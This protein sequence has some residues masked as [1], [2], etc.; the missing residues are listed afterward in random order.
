MVASPAAIAG[1][2]SPSAMVSVDPPLFCRGLRKGSPEMF[3][4]PV[5]VLE[6]SIIDP[7]ST[8]LLRLVPMV[9]PPT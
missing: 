2:P 4:E 8:R 6:E 5:G 9:P 3:P 7:S 1:L